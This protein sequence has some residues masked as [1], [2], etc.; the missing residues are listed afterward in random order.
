[1]REQFAG[2]GLYD[3]VAVCLDC[4]HQHL[5]PKAEQVTTQPWLDWQAKHRGHET[6]VIPHRALSRLGEKVELR[7]N[8]DVKVAYAA[9]AAY[10]I[11]L[12]SLAS[13]TNLLAGRE[14][15]WVSNA[16]NKYLDELVAGKITVGTTPTANTVIEVSAVGPLDD[17]PTYPDVF[18]GTDSN[19]T[20]SNAGIKTS[21]C[22]PVAVISVPAATSD[23]A[24]PFA[25]CG[26]RQ[27]FG[28]AM[29][30]THG[31]F[32]VHN[33][34]AALNATGANHAIS[35]TPVYATVV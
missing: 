19:E 22:L 15:T 24:Y 32:V 28:D 7:H 4:R 27:L 17:T 23:L 12:A 18:D 5:I 21:I 20:I 9:S 1:M 13:D 26:L 11:T 29:P 14:G 2:W 31:L 30:V 6:F 25:P 10:T 34:V 3:N 16:S 8:A 35:H 33:T